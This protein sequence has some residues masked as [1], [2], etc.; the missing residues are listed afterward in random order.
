MAN[1]S[2]L[3]GLQ[4][5]LDDAKGKWVEELYG[6]LWSLR[7][8][9]KTTTGETLFMLAYGSEAFLLIEIS[10]HTYRLTTFQENL[11]YAA[12]RE[13]L[14]LLRSIRSDALLREALYKLGIT[15]LHNGSVRM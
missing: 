8:T 10:L 13:A 4:K 9:E 11:N 15:R 14:D 12:L 1:K 6:V 5:K 3:H 2:I 7:T